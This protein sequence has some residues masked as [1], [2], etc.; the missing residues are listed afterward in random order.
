MVQITNSTD[1]NDEIERANC[2]QAIE[3]IATTDQLQKL[4]KLTSDPEMIEMLN[5]LEL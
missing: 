4:A 5:A 1:F 2:L 3:K